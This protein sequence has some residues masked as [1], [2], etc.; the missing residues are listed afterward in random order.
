MRD[1]PCGQG[2]GDPGCLARRVKGILGPDIVGTVIHI[3]SVPP[4]S[5]LAGRLWD[6]EGGRHVHL[7]AAQAVP[8]GAVIPFLSYWVRD[9]GYAAMVGRAVLR[10][11]ST[12]RPSPPPASQRAGKASRSPQ[13][14]SGT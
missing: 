4:P 1:W 11:P 7:R 3:H 8:F 14:R 2:R 9:Q 10:Q 12:T 13:D 5:P 6:S